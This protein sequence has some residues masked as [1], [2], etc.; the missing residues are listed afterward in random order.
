VPGDPG[1]IEELHR[2]GAIGLKAFMCES[3]IDDFAKADLPTLRAGMQRAAGLDMLVAVH[4]EFDPPP[5]TA[6][7]GWRDY[8]ASRPVSLELDAI[9][10]ATDIA[11]ETGCRL[12]IVHVSSGSGVALIT[13]ARARGVDVTCETCPHYLVLTE[14]DLERLGAAGKCAPPLRQK[15]ERDDLL[16]RLRAGEVATIGSDHSPSPP[17]M[18]THANFFKVWGGISGCQHL[19]PLLVDLELDPQLIARLTGSAVSERFRLPQKG[20]LEIGCDADLVLIDGAGGLEITAGSLEYRHRQSAYIGRRVHGRISR[21]ILRGRT[22]Y[23]DGRIV[24][25]PSGRLL[26]PTGLT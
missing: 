8:V 12:H 6:G 19:L 9:Q 17:E 1:H 2:A 23:L 3:G 14:D 7:A 25:A 15:A 24:A 22:V 5:Q 18:K 21:T 4:A 16:T 10:A 11:G 13:E 26:V 20:K